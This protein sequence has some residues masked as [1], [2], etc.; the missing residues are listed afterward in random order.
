MVAEVSFDLPGDGRCGVGGETHASG[1]VVAAGRF[2]EAHVRDLPDVVE[3][4]GVR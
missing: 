2:D 4:V 1:L 3:I